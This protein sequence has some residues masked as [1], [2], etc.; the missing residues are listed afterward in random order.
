[1]PS[2]P[3]VAPDTLPGGSPFGFVRRGHPL[4]VDVERF[5]ESAA[6]APALGELLAAEGGAPAV[7][8]VLRLY[9]EGPSRLKWLSVSVQRWLTSGFASVTLHYRARKQRLL[10]FELHEDPLLPGSAQFEGETAEV[11]RYVPRRRLT[12]RAADGR[13]GKCV[14]ACDLDGSWRR[15]HAVWGGARSASFAVAEPAGLDRERSV[16]YQRAL[17]GDDLAEKI[18]ARNMTVLLRGAGRIHAELQ[19]LDVRG[20]PDWHPHEVLPEIREHARLV[21]LFRPEAS[22]LV[23]EALATLLATVPRP[24]P[25]AFCH[26]D[27]RC[28]HLLEHDGRWSVIDLDGCRI[29]DPC[30]DVS[31]LLAFLKRDVPYVAERFAAADGGHD[32]LDRAIAAFLAGHAER[33][34]SP[35]EPKRLTWY[36]LAH[37]LDFLARM[38]K[39]DLFAPHAFERGLQRL[40]SLREQLGELLGNGRRA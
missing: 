5:W 17:E 2:S 6:R 37:E 27:L 1:M 3:A 36:L 30:Q 11:L 24:S 16:F 18:D 13:I 8:S 9:P 35:L 14:A 10:E 32:E 40:V 29:G 7:R 31:R 23:A 25:P 39:R 21:A 33:A 28:G 34:R 20:V 15:L 4:R 38:F 26:G 19:S 22:A 12:F